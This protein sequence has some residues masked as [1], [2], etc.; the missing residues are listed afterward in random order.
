MEGLKK[1]YKKTYSHFS[2]LDLHKESLKL[3][4][5]EVKDEIVKAK[6]E[7]LNELLPEKLKELTGSD[8]ADLAEYFEQE[9]QRLQK[10][11]KEF[12]NIK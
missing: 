10:S 4:A 5:L 11:V 12:K 3:N 6:I 2:Y 7:A 9:K 1:I 8:F